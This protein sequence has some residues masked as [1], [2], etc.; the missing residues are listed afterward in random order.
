MDTKKDSIMLV[1]G[2]QKKALRLLELG[3]QDEKVGILLDERPE[4]RKWL[5]N[6]R[7]VLK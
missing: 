1:I 3:L 2:F 7:P 6:T 4:Q 5:I